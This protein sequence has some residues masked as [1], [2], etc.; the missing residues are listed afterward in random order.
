MHCDW[1]PSGKGAGAATFYYGAR[2]PRPWSAASRA[3]QDHVVKRTGFDDCSI[4]AKTWDLLRMTRM[5]TV[6]LEAGY[7]SNTHDLERLT[8]PHSSGVRRSHRLGDP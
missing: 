3:L 6:R 4:H 1:E 7:L 5:A 8:E 2:G